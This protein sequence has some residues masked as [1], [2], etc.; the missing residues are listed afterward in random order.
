MAAIGGGDGE[1]IRVAA[2]A[3]VCHRAIGSPL[4][5]ARYVRAWQSY[6]R[7]GTNTGAWVRASSV[8]LGD[9]SVVVSVDALPQGQSITAI[10][11][12]FQRQ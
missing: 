4:T 12:S 1:R 9:S 10:N 5:L 7:T 8:K 6:L 3:A 11:Y 2:A